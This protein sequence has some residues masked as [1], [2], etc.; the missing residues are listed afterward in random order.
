MLSVIKTIFVA[1]VAL[2]IV[3][4]Q[5]MPAK[6]YQQLPRPPRKG[7]ELPAFEAPGEPGI[8]AFSDRTYFMLD[9]LLKWRVGET[10]TIIEIPPGFV[11]DGASIPKVVQLLGLSPYGAHGRAAVVHDYLYWSQL[12]TRKQADNIMLIAMKESGVSLLTQWLIAAA[13][14]IFGGS[15]WRENTDHLKNGFARVIQLDA[16][17][18]PRPPHPEAIPLG[19]REFPKQFTW[20]EYEAFLKQ[21]GVRDTFPSEQPYFCKFGNS[22]R[23]PKTANLV[24]D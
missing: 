20:R 1:A 3:G 18:T 17:K 10:A 23:V 24:D 22:T 8:A 2:A 9:T 21:A 6:D 7:V 16:E 11:S 4:C 12:C 15:P 5:T 14:K 13:V 19:A